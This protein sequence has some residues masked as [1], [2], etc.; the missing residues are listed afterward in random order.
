MNSLDRSAAAK[1][2][3][4]GDAAEYYVSI[5]LDKIIFWL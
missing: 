3:A 4:E 2:Y 1:S 5:N